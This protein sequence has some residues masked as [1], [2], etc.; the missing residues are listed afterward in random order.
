MEDSCVAGCPFQES[1]DL[2]S[3]RYALSILWAL[4][5]V[6]PRRFSEIKAE[7]GI[8]PVT[9]S[10]RLKDFEEAGLIT[11][12]TYNE[13]PPRVDYALTTKGYD[14]LPLIDKIEG[15]ANKWTKLENAAAEA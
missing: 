8:N 6:S 13:I 2:L 11:R 4:Q 5:Q 3:R 12:T 9:L 14:L 1:L 15:W 10:Q 7:L